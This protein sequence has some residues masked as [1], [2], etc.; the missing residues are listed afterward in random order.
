MLHKILPSLLLCCATGA[1]WAQGPSAPQSESGRIEQMM[2][3]RSNMSLLRHPQQALEMADAMTEPGFMAVAMSMSANPEAWLKAMEQASEPSILKNFSQAADP[4]VVADWFYSSM[5]PKFQQ[6]ILSRAIDSKKAQRC[7]KAMTDPRFFM[8]A[9][10]MMSPVTP[11]QWMKVSAD[12]RIFKP[13]QAWMDPN[14]YMNWMRL[15][16]EAPSKKDNDKA[17]PTIPFFWQAPQRY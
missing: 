10:A 12:G 16:V 2:D 1:A 5:D 14:T 4:Q 13:M 6:A 11:M 17:A 3:T 9:L 15:P 7:M 8:P